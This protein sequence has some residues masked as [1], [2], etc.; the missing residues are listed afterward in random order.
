MW[1]LQRKGM[2]IYIDNRIMQGADWKTMYKELQVLEGSF[3]I[4]QKQIVAQEM[5]TVKKQK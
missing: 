3:N 1:H 5:I 4:I 2:I